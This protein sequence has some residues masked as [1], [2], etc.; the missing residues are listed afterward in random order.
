MKISINWLKEF[1]EFSHTPAELADE[2]TAIGLEATVDDPAYDFSGVVVGQVLEAVRLPESDHLSLCKVTT[3]EEP[4]DIVC[5]APNVEAGQLV[6][7]AQV[8]AKLAGGF[9]IKKSKIRGQVSQGMICAEDELGLSADHTGIMVL[10]SDAVIGED[11][12]DYLKRTVDIT[13]DL[14]LTPNRGDCF[15]HLGVA[16][17]LAAK[18]ELPLRFPAIDIQESDTAINELAKVSI[19][20]TDGCHRYAARVITGVKIG[21][22][23][24]WLAGRLEAVGIR[25][26]NNIVDASNYVLMELGHPLHI[27]DYDNLAGHEIDVYFAQPG[28]QFTTLDNIKRELNDFH[29]M[30]ADGKGPVALAGVMGGLDS[31]VTDTTTNVLI[32]SAYFAPSVIRKSAKSLDLGTE[33]SKRFE[34]DTDIDGLIIALDR[35]T[36]LIVDLA[37]GSVAKG[38]LDVYPVR[39]EPEEIVLSCT[40]TNRLLGTNIDRAEML[41]YLQRLGL[42]AL[43]QDEDD[44]HCKV[45]LSRPELRLP[46]DL[47]E[48][49]ARLK[50]YDNLPAVEGITVSFDSFIADGQALHREIRDRLVKIG[51][52]EHRSN[53]LTRADLVGALSDSPAVQLANPL[54]SEMAYMR[55]DLVP[56]LLQAT[57]FNERRQT[58]DVLLF[59]I[60]AVHVT[61]DSAYNKTQETFKLGLA[62]TIGPDTEPL[63][64]KKSGERDAFYLKGVIET[65]A[66]Q[67]GITDLTFENSNLPNFTAAHAIYGCGKLLGYMGLPDEG[68]SS[69]VDLSTPTIIAEINLDA[70]SEIELSKSAY[71]EIVPYPV[72]DRDMALEVSEDVSAHDLLQKVKERGGKNLIDAHIFDLYSG[73]G[74]EAGHK[75]I[76]IRLHFQAQ[77]RTLTDD[78]VDRP[79]GKIAEALEAEFK[80]KWRRST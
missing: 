80:A 23:P 10:D 35:V 44:I 46:V 61:D 17:D 25:S 5:G 57:A 72:V 11:F 22:S 42:E 49:I 9:K 79:V 62:A 41:G 55:T 43:P 59:E 48:E 21:P 63:H 13:V 12:K 73:Q 29:L 39:H 30:I 75:S 45:P 18:L 16:R 4:V 3:G 69:L 58:K 77:D 37:G 60:G 40:F 67:I 14:D 2:L 36:A 68:L 32:E 27:F 8:G 78:E 20:S 76:A 33:A 24:A 26:I 54:S 64:W 51:F 56:G 66:N 47:I 74:I 34:R 38:R 70:L 31:E 19:S 7:V 71:N 50:G 6:A 15:S 1:V 65:I 52:H 53:S 28:Q